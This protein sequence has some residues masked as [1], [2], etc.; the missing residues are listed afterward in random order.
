MIEIRLGAQDLGRVRFTT[1][2]VWETAASLNVLAVPRTHM[3]HRRLA[4]RVER[5]PAYDSSLLAD[6]TGNRAWI[7]DTLGPA[8]RARPGDPVAQL[9]RLLETEPD[10]VAQDLETLRRHRPRSR[11]PD[12]G[13][14]EFLEAVTRALTGYW[15]A[16]LEP[17]WERVHNIT[18]ADIAHHRQLLAGEGLEHLVP[19]LH[20]DLT[21]TRGVVT[22]GL[23]TNAVVEAGGNGVWLVPSVFRW[24]W[25]AVDI[26]SG[27][28]VI[29]YAARGAGR[30]WEEAEEQADAL[31]ALLGQ[32]RAALLR[33]L[34]VPR[35]TTA[36]AR[37]VGLAP[38]TVSEHLG[39]MTASGLLTS[40]RDGRK[41]LYSRTNVGDLVVAGE[42]ALA[43]L[44]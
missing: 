1:D 25:L 44:G 33:A 3:L 12:M 27:R 15:R 24:P 26:R 17:L 19:H 20:H 42:S 23:A 34:V 13:V 29:C 16:V 32:S 4:D 41:V 21:M 14:E 18:Q 11:V 22:A 31:G 2:A 30:V 39:V 6:L 8:P 35:T 37:V 9:Q 28:P 40:T 43:R 36:L 10:V 5:R 7:P 38:S